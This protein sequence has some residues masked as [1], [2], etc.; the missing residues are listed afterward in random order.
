MSQLGRFAPEPP[1]DVPHLGLAAMQPSHSATRE[2]TETEAIPAAKAATGKQGAAGHGKHGH[3]DHRLPKRNPVAVTL[4]ALA[5]VVVVSGFGVVMLGKEHAEPKLTEPILQVVAGNVTAEPGSRAWQYVKFAKPEL[6]EP[7]RPLPV[8]GRVGFDEAATG[9][10][11]AP[12]QGRVEKVHAQLGQTVTAG[13]VLVTVRSGDMVELET[14]QRLAETSVL[15]QQRTVERVKTLVQLQA[16]PERELLAAQKELKEAQL[17]LQASKLKQQSLRVKA[18]A[19]GEFDILAPRSGVVVQRQVFVGQ[20]VAP[21]HETPLL[22]IADLSEVLAIASVPEA[23]VRGLQPGQKAT[24]ALAGGQSSGIDGQI[25]YVS[26]VVDLDRHTVDVR[27]RV[28]NTEGQLRPNAWVQVQ[29]PAHGEKRLVLPMS[30]VVTDDQRTAVFVK[31]SP[32]KVAK[33][34]VVVGRQR[35]GLSEVL[36]GVQPADDVVVQGALLLLNSVQLAN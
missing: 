11:M 13:E 21:D 20:E 24:V 23:D 34:E 6:A 5:I 1:A 36:S 32:G 26:P 8:A 4:T 9:R 14:A 3:D 28:R 29:F 19:D 15:A 30:A 27:V 12:L 2:L 17:T 33:R 10:V 31:V 22:M 16:L 18:R 25:E 35:D 7:L